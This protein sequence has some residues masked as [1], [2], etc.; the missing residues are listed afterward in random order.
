MV[1]DDE[2]ERTK[3]LVKPHLKHVMKNSVNT[4]SRRQFLG[5]I[6][7]GT[8]AVTV[9]PMMAAE[10]GLAS[11]ALAEATPK[12]LHFGPLEPLVS[13]MQETEIAKLQPALVQKLREGET[14]DRLVAAAALANARTFGGEDY[15]GFH[16]LMAMTPALRMS[17]SLAAERAAL[18]VLKVLYRNTNRIQEKGG[19]S[20]EVL[21]ALAPTDGAAPTAS[22]RDLVRRKDTTGAERCLSSLAST[23]P[24][25]ALD[26]LL[27]AVQEDTEV[28]RTVLP[29]RA[30]DLL[31]VVGR[32]HAETLLRQSVRYCINAEGWRSPEWDAHGAVLVK[33]FDQ[34]S[35]M[36]K[37]PGNRPAEDAWVLKLSETIFSSTPAQAAEAVAAALAEGFSPAVIGEALSLAANQLVLRD[38]GRTPSLEVSGKPIGSVHGDSIGVHASDSANAWRHLASVSGPRNAH[39]CLILGAW[40]MARDRTA[41]GGDFANWEP[42]PLQQHLKGLSST[43][44]A[45]ILL[46]AD[47]AIR[48]N[49]QARASAI[50]HRYGQLGHPAGPAFDLMLR[51]ATNEDGSLHAEKYFQTARDDFQ[52]TRPALQW[53]HLVGLARVTA[54]EF[55]RPAPGQAEAR[56]LLGLG[57][58]A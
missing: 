45:A 21:T 51:H 50:I 48:Q 17:R 26:A 1:Y 15:I 57:G 55:G 2:Q 25:A 5:E 34:F 44:P 8:L 13:F 29:Y 4:S 46:E 9:G 33:L 12:A 19:R 39:A 24:E 40:Q 30:W 32:D 28:H 56:S 53:R 20:N 41:R 11:P 23:K 27:E 54:S 3:R 18:P 38:H 10:L 35:L 22:L 43:D 6:G 31:E 49:L 47:E 37:P 42:L 58:S 16:T 14:L 52:S 36:G 7:K